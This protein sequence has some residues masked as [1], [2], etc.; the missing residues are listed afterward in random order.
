M[1]KMNKIMANLIILILLGVAVGTA[2]QLLIKRGL[3]DIG[4][5]QILSIKEAVS[6]ALKMLTNRFILMGLA[7]SA[8]AAFFGFI[9][10]SRMDLSLFYPISLGLFL[11]AITMSSWLILKEPVV[12][13]KIIGIVI[14][15]LGIIIL[16]R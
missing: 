14:I 2:G 16:S 13:F 4:E 1:I 5:I 6:A 3:S 7:C 10:L 11:V 12:C 8:V 9:A 15:F